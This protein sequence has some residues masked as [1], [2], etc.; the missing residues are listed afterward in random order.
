MD[1]HEFISK[2]VKQDKRNI[3]EKFEGNID[4]IPN[5]L[6]SFFR[7]ADPVDVEIHID[8]NP[9]KMYSVNEIMELQ[10]DYE[11]E[12]GSFVFATCNADPIF[13]FKQSIYTYP[14]GI[15]NPQ[16][17]LFAEDFNSFMEMID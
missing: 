3:F 5:E 12:A 2:A 8:G 17:E 10:K 11:L 16:K 7:E 15:T 1:I 6:R 14:H 4:F 13:I 9:I